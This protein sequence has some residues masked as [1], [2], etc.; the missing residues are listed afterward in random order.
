MRGL[1][2]LLLLSFAGSA[3]ATTIESPAKGK[4]FKR[5]ERI[6]CA[7]ISD[8]GGGAGLVLVKTKKNVICGDV[9]SSAMDSGPWTMTIKPPRDSW[10]VGELTIEFLSNRRKGRVEATVKIIVE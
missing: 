9:S 6:V 5:G 1:T 7:G 8:E 10:P 2:I 4:V 3:W